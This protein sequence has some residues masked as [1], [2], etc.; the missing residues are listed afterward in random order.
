MSCLYFHV[1]VIPWIVFSCNFLGW[2]YI[3]IIWLHF[4][5][6]IDRRTRNIDKYREIYRT[7][8][9]LRL[10]LRR[11]RRFLDQLWPWVEPNLA[12][13]SLKLLLAERNV[14]KSATYQCCETGIRYLHLD[15]KRSSLIFDWPLNR[16]DGAFQTFNGRI[17]SENSRAELSAIW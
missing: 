13:P 1:L 8:I 14:K 9:L 15:H 11:L 10:R 12:L 2:A 16:L 7:S 5:K 4:E 3:I 6:D 17:L